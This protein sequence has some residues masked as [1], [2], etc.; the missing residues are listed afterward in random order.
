MNIIFF[1]SSKYSL[2]GARI[3]HDKIGL[4]AVVTLP[5]R[6]DKRGNSTPNPLR[7]FAEEQGLT[8][9]MINK[10]DDA[11]IQN[12]A[13][14]QPDFLIVEDYGLIL[15][16]KLL[17]LPKYASLNIHHSLLPK[18]RG[19][20]PA[21]S[22]ILAGEKKTGVSVI[23]MAKKVD[24]GAIL[25]QQEYAVKPDETTDSL[26]RVLN[27]IGGEIIIPIIQDYIKGTA[28]P[29]V[30]DAS[31][32]TYTKQ[33][34]KKD[35]FIDVINPP[36]PKQLDR[37][38]RAYYPW[39]I[40]WTKLLLTDEEKIV[41]F[42]PGGKL[43]VEGKKIMTFKD[44]LN[45]Y[46]EQQELITKLFDKRNKEARMKPFRPLDDALFEMAGADL[47]PTEPEYCSHCGEPVCNNCADEAFKK[48]QE[49][50]ESSLF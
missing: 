49:E 27:Q 18:Y 47:N 12:L 21:P 42:F 43:Q 33:F 36:S 5:D 24:A 34:T 28:K 39:P 10:L 26:L 29:T 38:I 50:E 22:A 3:L 44:F 17:E 45:G 8:L 4:S 25:T 13:I 9:F 48:E 11:T 2:I 14:L 40:V 32:A 7:S 41:K 46:P 31:Q 1:G 37:M 23:T 15:P 20:S 35:S 19:A 16:E 6:P 30:Q